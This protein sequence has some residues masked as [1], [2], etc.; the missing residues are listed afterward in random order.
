MQSANG[1][2]DESLGLMENLK[3]EIGGMKLHVQAHVIRNP[4]YD[5]LLSRPFDV[6][7][8]LYLAT[9]SLL[10]LLLPRAQPPVYLSPL[11]C[12]TYCLK[13]TLIL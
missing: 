5:V 7:T 6:L 11:S 10:D 12:T 1:L 2:H 13:T 3:L 4:A 9:P 8:A